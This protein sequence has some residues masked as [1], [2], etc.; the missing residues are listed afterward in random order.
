MIRINRE[1][2]GYP[3]RMSLQNVLNTIEVIKADFFI[4]THN[5]KDVAAA[6][7]FHVAADVVQ[8]IYWGDVPGYTELRAMNYLAYKVFEYYA[9]S[10]IKL[11]DIGPSSENGIPNYGLC[12]FKE[13]IGCSVSLK[14][15]FSL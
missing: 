11:I 4:L 12:E 13:N 6:Q 8:V 15:T 5:A 3:L 7:V 9:A 14:Y 2:K 10:K 1:S